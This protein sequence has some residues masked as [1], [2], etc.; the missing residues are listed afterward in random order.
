[1]K[2]SPPEV[3]V[4][5]NNDCEYSEQAYDIDTIYPKDKNGKRRINEIAFVR[6]FMET[7]DLINVNGRFYNLDGMVSDTQI[8]QDIYRSLSEVFTEKI[9][10]NTD[11]LFK[12]LHYCA[13]KEKMPTYSTKIPLQNGTL[14]IT[15]NSVKLYESKQHAPYR[16]S[17]N[18]PISNGELKD[19]PTPNFD[20]WITDLLQEED[21]PL[22][23]EMLGYFL[24]PITTA[25]KCF[26][27]IGKGEEGK[28]IWGYLLE[29]MF[30]NA[31]TS[32]EIKDIESNRF[33]ISDLENKLVCYIDDLSKKALSS[34]EKFK[35][36][37]TATSS[38]T[39]ERKFGDSFQFI[40]YARLIACSNYML[41]AVDDRSDG[42]YRRIIPIITK[43]C[44][45][46][47]VKIRNLHE[48]IAEEKDG[49]FVWAI[50]GV[51][52]LIRNNFKF[53]VSERSKE[54]LQESRN[55]AENIQKFVDDDLLFDSELQM[56][57]KNLYAAYAK[58]CADNAEYK[59]DIVQ[60]RSF[61][62]E[63]AAKWRLRS[64]ENINDCG[65]RARGYKGVGLKTNRGRV[66]ITS[67]GIKND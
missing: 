57:T 9:T 48:K 15:S 14:E 2:F 33:A 26:I 20:K 23:Q 55:D 46:N 35:Q 29:R 5:T 6:A 25:Q 30:G 21:I 24:L 44:P 3:E 49:I 67:G 18:L 66:N 62:K 34:T 36:I 22:A 60:F 61:I 54:T 32:R 10:Q 45:P 1:M 53:S 41:S 43:P 13:H 17:V 42:F 52:R 51:Q 47:R 58:W 16:L 27:F 11:I 64:S 28:S 56:T 50:A 4:I 19:V 59:V 40:P 7:N 38:V 63:N 39:A 12:A 37:V 65:V 31:F 8:K